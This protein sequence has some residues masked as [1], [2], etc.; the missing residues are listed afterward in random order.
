MSKAVNIRIHTTMMQPAAMY[1][2]ETWSVRDGHEKTE[3][4]GEE[5]MKDIWTGGRTRNI[6]NKNYS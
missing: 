2:S 4:M 3:Y 5:N 1:G 6:V